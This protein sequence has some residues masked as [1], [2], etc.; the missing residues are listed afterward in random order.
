MLINSLMEMVGLVQNDVA[1]INHRFFNNWVN[2]C[3]VEPCPECQ[4]IGL[5]TI[6]FFFELLFSYVLLQFPSMFLLANLFSIIHFLNLLTTRD[7][8]DEGEAGL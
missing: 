1:K 4:E 8:Q 3:W 7:P 5:V 6:M 2:C